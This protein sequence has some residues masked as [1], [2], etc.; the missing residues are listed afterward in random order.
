MKW[1][2]LRISDMDGGWG[3]GWGVEDML[4]VANIGLKQVGD[5]VYFLRWLGMHKMGGFI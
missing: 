4:G 1:M 5:M 2:E 3:C